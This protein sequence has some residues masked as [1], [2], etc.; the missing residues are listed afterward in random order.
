MAV[1][2]RKVGATALDEGWKMKGFWLA[3]AA[4]V[5][6]AP[7]ARAE[8]DCDTPIEAA[9]KLNDTPYHMTMTTFDASG[10][11]DVSEI[12][13][14]DD[15]TYVKIGNT[16]HPGPKEALTLGD[17]DDMA[18]AEQN[19]TCLQAGSEAV[20]GTM[21]DVWRVDDRSDPGEPKRQTVWI[22]KDTGQ[23]VRLE[24]DVD[25]GQDAAHMVADIDYKD[26]APPR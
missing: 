3:F 26:V 9:L 25:E 2:E 15:A 22:A 6:L 11:S 24:L 13:S 12:I 7:A 21:S 17:A 19:M 10:K 1:P 16:W 23:L 14:L 18:E 20:N 5:T 4:A 8:G